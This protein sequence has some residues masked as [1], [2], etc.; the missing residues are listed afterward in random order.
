M[1]LIDNFLPRFRDFQNLLVSGEFTDVQ[2][3][4]DQVTYPHIL[5]GIPQELQELV[6]SAIEQAIGQKIKDPTT[7]IRRSPKGSYATHIFH[8]DSSMG[9]MSLMVYFDSK[10]GFGTGFAR[11]KSTGLDRPDDKPEHIQQFRDDKNDKAKW[12][13][14]KRTQAAPNRAVIFDSSLFHCALPI[15]G[16]GEGV[17]ARTVL[18]CFFNL[19]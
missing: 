6:V 5:T 7:F 1:K 17:N 15:G 18:T 19:D 9:E 4:A 12:L 16:F 10:P 11:H 8:N 2:N 13:V 14:K 3:P